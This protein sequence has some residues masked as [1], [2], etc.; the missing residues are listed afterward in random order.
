LEYSPV[1]AYGI[2]KNTPS[3]DGKAQRLFAIYILASPDRRK[4]YWHMPVIGRSDDDRVDI[5]ASYQLSKIVVALTAPESAGPASG[6][7]VLLNGLSSRFP[8]QVLAFIAI[9]VG[10]RAVFGPT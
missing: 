4:R 2:G 5:S 1:S 8:S 7:I 10:V 9:A 6:C 3:T